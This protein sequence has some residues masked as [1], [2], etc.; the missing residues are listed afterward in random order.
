[1]KY[2]L[3][4]LALSVPAQA[5][6]PARPFQMTPAVGMYES[7][8]ITRQ[9]LGMVAKDNKVEEETT[10]SAADDLNFRQKAMRG[11]RNLF[12]RGESK[13]DAGDATTVVESRN[14]LVASKE[15]IN[16]AGMVDNTTLMAKSSS[17]SSAVESKP[18]GE[19]EEDSEVKNMLQKIKES[20]KAGVISYA[21]WELGFWLTSLPI[22]L[23]GYYELAGHWPDLSNSEDMA[24]LGAEAFAFVNFARFAVPL[25]IGL[26]LST[27]GWVKDNVVDRFFPDE[28]ASDNDNKE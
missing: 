28:S 26:A 7:R 2:I 18:Q 3:L 1:M 17:M 11:F 24:K 19:N 22:A 27:T 10:A 25:R 8:T 5:F 15:T 6:A 21:L 4:S 20:G 12:R 23:F 16:S 14:D 13:V 9:R